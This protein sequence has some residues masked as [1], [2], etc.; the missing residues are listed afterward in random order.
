CAWTGRFINSSS[1]TRF[2][3]LFPYLDLSLFIVAA[4]LPSLVAHV[5]RNVKP[6]RSAV[7]E[8]DL[9]LFRKLVASLLIARRV[10]QRHELFYC[11]EP[12]DRSR[13]PRGQM[14]A[15]FRKQCISFEKCGFDE[16]N[17]GVFRK[18]NDLFNIRDGK[19]TID[20][21]GNLTARSDFHDLV[22]EIAK[23]KGRRLAGA[24]FAPRN[25]Y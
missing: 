22:F 11:G 8:C 19:G 14:L 12:G 17:V 23:G 16:K 6:L 13:L 1:G 2:T 15:R 5:S 3:T 20:N 25:L 4:M 24:R 9:C 18:P 21:I 7:H 10:V